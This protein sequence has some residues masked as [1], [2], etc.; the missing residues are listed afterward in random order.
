MRS[1]FVI[2]CKFCKNGELLGEVGAGGTAVDALGCEQRGAF[3][4]SC[5]FRLLFLFFQ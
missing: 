4:G 2:Y 1:I 5:E 3:W